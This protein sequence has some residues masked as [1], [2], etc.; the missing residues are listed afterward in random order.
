MNRYFIHVAYVGTAFNGSQVQG[1][2]PTVQYNINKALSTILRSQIETYG[3]SRTD[4]GVH[5]LEN[6]YHFD[7]EALDI[8]NLIYRMN[9]L[10]PK[11]ISVQNIRIPKD[12]SSNCRFDAIHRQYRYKIHFKRNPFLHERSYYY[13]FNIDFETL[14]ETAKIIPNF[15]DFETFSKKNTQS[16]TNLCTIYKSEWN[17]NDDHLEYIVIANRFLRGMVRALVGTQLNA[18]RGKFS[19]LEFQQRIEAKNCALA[20]FS[21]PGHGL[22]LEKITYPDDYFIDL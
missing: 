2:L 17:M 18:A 5:A 8:D 16:H 11:T 21:V 12:P 13:P 7:F 20:D 3:A 14:V 10:L 9:A 1:E 6:V 4:E 22:Y 15:T 19:T